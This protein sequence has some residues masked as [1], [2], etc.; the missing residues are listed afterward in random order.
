MDADGSRLDGAWDQL[1][2]YLQEGLHQDFPSC[3]QLATLE[4]K[5]A[6][7]V[8]SLSFFCE[9]VFYNFFFFFKEHF[10]VN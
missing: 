4:L 1:V 2:S 9:N 3:S 5:A 7:V 6:A 10:A 8:V